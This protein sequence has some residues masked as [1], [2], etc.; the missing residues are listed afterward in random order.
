MGDVLADTSVWI[1]YFRRGKGKASDLLDELL[2][3]DRVVLCGVVEMELL[4]G[5]RSTERKELESLLRSLHFVETLREDFIAAGNML[6]RLRAK[7]VT[8]PATDALI[9][10]VCCRK[11]LLMLS[12]DEHFARFPGLRRMET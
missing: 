11:D 9:S 7:G 12:L 5:V 6:N 2:E 3:Q 1:E 4:R 8:V 10:A